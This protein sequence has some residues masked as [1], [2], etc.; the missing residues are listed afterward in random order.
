MERNL[1]P[2]DPAR[3]RLRATLDHV[4][5]TAALWGTSDDVRD[6]NHDERCDAV[7]RAVDAVLTARQR[8]IVEWHFF[9]GVSQ[10]DIARRLGVTQQVVQKSLYGV[11]RRG[12][13]IGG[14]LGRLRD[15]LASRV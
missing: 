13:R 1:S 5:S 14:A 6:D 15:A 9:E 3:L 10:G 4:P 7:R 2:A 11:N 12:R 8:E